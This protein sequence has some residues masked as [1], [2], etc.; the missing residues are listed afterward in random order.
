MNAPDSSGDADEE[1][2]AA[3]ADDPEREEA[4]RRRESDPP[5]EH[6]D[7]QR[8][9][10]RRGAER[11][12]DGAEPLAARHVRGH[13]SRHRRR[14]CCERCHG[15]GVDERHQADAR[16]PVQRAE[17]DRGDGERE[18]A[19]QADESVVPHVLGSEM[20]ER[21]RVAEGHDGAVEGRQHD[22]DRE[23]DEHALFR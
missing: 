1:G 10:T 17:G 5:Q 22:H 3:S 8:R 19:P 4:P 23:H 18:T 15:G 16:D 13:I 7:E 6:A 9:E 14:P 2:A 20:I 11:R 21:D 12:P